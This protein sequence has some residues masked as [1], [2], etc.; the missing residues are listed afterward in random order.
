MI[1]LSILISGIQS[2]RMEKCDNSACVESN[3]LKN[4]LVKSNDIFTIA[5]MNPTIG[6]NDTSRL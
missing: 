4:L 1:Y 5:N 2:H 6:K 3:S